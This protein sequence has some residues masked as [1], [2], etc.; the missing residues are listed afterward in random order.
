MLEQRPPIFQAQY[1]YRPKKFRMLWHQSLDEL[2]RYPEL[3]RECINFDLYPIVTNTVNTAKTLGSTISTRHQRYIEDC[4]IVEKWLADDLAIRTG[5]YHALLRFYQNALNSGEYLIWYPKDKTDKAFIIEIL[6]VFAGDNENQNINPVH[7]RTAK[8]YRWLRQEVNF[9][10]RI[11]RV[12]QVPEAVTFL[13]G[14]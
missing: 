12:Y 6:A 5:F 8:D 9:K 10:F 1:N 14:V 3:P 13:D 11:L 4:I 7:D 2:L